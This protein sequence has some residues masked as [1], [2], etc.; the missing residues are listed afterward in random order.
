VHFFAGADEPC[1]YPAIRFRERR[2]LR[3][4]KLGND[5][6]DWLDPFRAFPRSTNAVYR[7]R[8][9]NASKT[10]FFIKKWQFL[11]FLPLDACS[12]SYFYGSG[13]G[14][15][16]AKT[17]YLAWHRVLLQGFLLHE[18]LFKVENF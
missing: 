2:R 4:S 12:E 14:F 10:T 13:T 7:I 8:R 3:K 5:G 6:F 17:Q 18:N 16:D 9:E 15:H 11:P 1:T